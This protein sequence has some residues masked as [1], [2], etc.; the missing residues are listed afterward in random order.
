MAPGG[1]LTDEQAKKLVRL[2]LKSGRIV[3]HHCKN[4]PGGK[5]RWKYLVFV[6]RTDEDYAFLVFNSNP[7]DL[8]RNSPRLMACLIPVV[9]GEYSFVTHPTVLSCLELVREPIAEVEAGL[10]AHP[11]HILEMISNEHRAKAKSISSP[12]MPHLDKQVLQV[13]L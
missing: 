11:S 3:Y 2:Q 13:C 8:Q 4:L 5:P 1:S 7:T 10:I 12:L 6:G 9:V